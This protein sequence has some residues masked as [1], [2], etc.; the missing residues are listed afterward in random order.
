MRRWP[1]EGSLPPFTT[2]SEGRPGTNMAAFC[3]CIMVC[4]YVL[5]ILRIYI[6]RCIL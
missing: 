2:I 6:R 5:D 4:I 1:S 3:V